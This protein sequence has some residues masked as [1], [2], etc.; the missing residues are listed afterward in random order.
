[1]LRMF[2]IALVASAFVWAGAVAVGN[3]FDHEYEDHVIMTLDGQ[4]L[5]CQRITDIQGRVF[6][7]SCEEIHAP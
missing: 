6:Y 3:A 5:D 1:M 2:L 4:T 7:D